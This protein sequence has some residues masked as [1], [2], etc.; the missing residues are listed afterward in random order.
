MT[1]VSGSKK[2]IIKPNLCC[3]LSPKLLCPRCDWALCKECLQAAVKIPRVGSCVLFALHP[4][5]KCERCNKDI[6][7]EK[8]NTDLLNWQGNT[9]YICTP[10]LDKGRVS[11][12]DFLKVT[13]EL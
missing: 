1:K 8:A 11:I 13:K 4:I 10:C 5:C 3:R 2:P 9:A 6:H 12:S 7:W